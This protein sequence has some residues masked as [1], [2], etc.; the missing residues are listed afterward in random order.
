MQSP[1][2]PHGLSFVVSFDRIPRYTLV[3]HSSISTQLPSVD[4]PPSIFTNLYPVSQTHSNDPPVLTQVPCS[5][6][7]TFSYF[8]GYIMDLNILPKRYILSKMC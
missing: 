3:L 5:P 8:R 4:S 1:W 7:F 2:D 6:Q